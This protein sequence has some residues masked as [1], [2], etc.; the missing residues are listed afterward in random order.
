[1]SWLRVTTEMIVATVLQTM[2]KTMSN[3]PIAA[4]NGTPT[5]TACPP[6]TVALAAS[7][8]EQAA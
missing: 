5:T 4:S 7:L 3:H 1:M 6:S 2:P 8:N